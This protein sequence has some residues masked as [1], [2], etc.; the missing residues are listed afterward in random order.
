MKKLG[1]GTMRLPK[2]NNENANIDIEEFKKMADYFIDQGF[3]YFDTAWFYHDEKSE[4]ACK[5]AVV[6][7]FDRESFQ[8]AD[9][10]PIAIL[11]EEGKSEEELKDDLENH[12]QT[13]LDRTGAGYFDYY[14]LH[15][16]DKE[17]FERA[18]IYKAYEFIKE[19][20]D[21][22]LIKNIGF[23]FH[24]THD[25]LE[26]IFNTYPDMDF[27]QLQINYLDLDHELI[28][29][30]KIFE[31]ARKRDLPII[32]M[33]PLK[34]GTLAQLP[35]EAHDLLKNA[36]PDIS[37]ASWA[38]RYAAGLEGVF[39][40]LS[41]MS[42]MD[43]VKDNIETMKDF[44]PL[45]DDEK[46]LIDKVIQIIKDTNAIACTECEYCLPECPVEIPIPSYFSCYNRDK[47]GLGFNNEERFENIKERKTKPEEC[48]ACGACEA[49]CPQ[50]LKI[51][52][53]LEEVDSY[54]S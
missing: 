21:Q 16:L 25:V 47:Q 8:L 5:E 39:M 7:R 17:K 49:I 20:K 46:A 13:Q 30:R 27:V 48:I 11:D 43:Q 29:S 52:S 53:L 32:I 28:Q 38:L 18:K 40:V 41:G 37:I 34:G 10:M 6:K 51:I 19:K 50:H 44:K 45:S 24:D 2:I 35:R 54:F 9:K 26:E 4:E 23:S 33:E 36:R 14:L 15:A 42:D 3:T 1:F 12:F 31:A 22:G